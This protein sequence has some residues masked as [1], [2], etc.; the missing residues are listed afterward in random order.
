MTAV[1]LRVTGLDALDGDSRTSHPQVGTIGEIG[2]SQ[3]LKSRND[4]SIVVVELPREGG[5]HTILGREATDGAWQFKIDGY[6]VT[7][8]PIDEEPIVCRG[9]WVPT[10]QGAL[11]QINV[12]GNS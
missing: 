11:G 7:P 10:L 12:S 2:R 4:G 9:D 8:A 3:S 6:G 1:L 5:G